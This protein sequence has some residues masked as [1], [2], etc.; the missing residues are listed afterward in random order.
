MH[1]Q[2]CVYILASKRNGTLYTGVTSSLAQRIWQ[3]RDG[4]SEGFT[5]KYGVRDLV[6][7]ELHST[8]TSAITW[9]K[10]IKSWRRAWKLKMIERFNPA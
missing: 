1:R 8:M 10:Q 4:L 6:W 9:E 7:Y 5:H 2:P 3:H